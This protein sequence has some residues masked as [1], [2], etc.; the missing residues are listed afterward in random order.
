MERIQEFELLVFG[1]FW[2]CSFTN[3]GSQKSTFIG[4]QVSIKLSCAVSPSGSFL[5][6]K[7]LSN[8]SNAIFAYGAVRWTVLAQT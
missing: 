4:L 6:E 7:V 2:L 5:M 8:T 3:Y 1:I